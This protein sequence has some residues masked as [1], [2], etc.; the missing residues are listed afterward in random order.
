MTTFQNAPIGGPVAEKMAM[1]LSIPRTGERAD[2]GMAKLANEAIDLDLGNEGTDG[3]QEHQIRKIV[4]RG[5]GTERG[6]ETGTATAIAAGTEVERETMESETATT[7]G[8]TAEANGVPAE[9]LHAR[10]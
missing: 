2:T 6:E 10:G 7:K 9:H 1:R 5:Q 8:R 4:G 3:V